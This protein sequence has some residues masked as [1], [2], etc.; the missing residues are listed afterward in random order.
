[1]SKDRDGHSLASVVGGFPYLQLSLVPYHHKY[2]ENTVDCGAEVKQSTSD[3]RFDSF[4]ACPCVGKTLNPHIAPS[5]LISVLHG[6]ESCL[7]KTEF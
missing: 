2:G 5:G 7:L 6:S 4:S 1:M 3:H